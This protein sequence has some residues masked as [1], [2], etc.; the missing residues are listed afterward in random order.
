[1]RIMY[2][3]RW[4]RTREDVTTAVKASFSE[5]RPI[6]T[7]HVLYSACPAIANITNRPRR[8]D[9]PAMKKR[10]VVTDVVPN[11]V[12]FVS[13]PSFIWRDCA[14]NLLC[15][16]VRVGLISRV[17][18]DKIGER[19]DGAI[20]HQ[21]GIGTTLVHPR[22]SVS[23]FT[24]LPGPIPEK[25]DHETT[26]LL[27]LAFELLVQVGTVPFEAIHVCCVFNHSTGTPAN[28]CNYLFFS[29][30]QTSHLCN[31]DI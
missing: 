29:F 11:P 17:W 18:A 6:M 21:Q 7:V 30:A 27:C 14:Q 8:L 24:T 2:D 28:V 22:K 20:D 1:M 26:W 13:H 16:H 3:S 4:D 10:D 9:D 12:P 23:R 15:T 5:A 31:Q 19:K 25:G